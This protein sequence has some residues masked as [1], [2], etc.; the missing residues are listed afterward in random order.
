M[1]GK[2]QKTKKI[3][4][5]GFSCSAHEMQYSYK[6]SLS[7]LKEFW[8]GKGRTE[9]FEK[10]YH[11]RLEGISNIVNK[12]KQFI[13][14]KLVLD[15]GCGPGIVASI[16]PHNTKVIGLDFSI[17]MLRSAKNRIRQLI[18]GDAFNLPF[19]NEVFEVATCFFVAS[20][21]SVKDGIFFEAY[22]ILENNGFFLFSDYSPNDEH[23]FLKRRISPLLGESCNIFIES[24][25]SLSNKL[26]RDGFKV[27]ATEFIKFAP[28]FELGRYIKS[29]KELERLRNADP[30]LW[31]YIQD[32]LSSK[33]IRREFIL[34]I[35]K[36]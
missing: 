21:Y 27:V 34:L 13:D 35:S 2:H 6:R 24:E 8:E 20:D 12:V 30:S 14:D 4:E 36:K 1:E 9:A 23:W 5:R 28:S 7:S 19:P 3:K 29:E 15:I 22:R 18:R 32:R 25:E 11:I 26:E 10:G 33:K 16:F 17:S 31:E